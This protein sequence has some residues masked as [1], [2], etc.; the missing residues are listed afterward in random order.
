[1]RIELIN[2][3]DEL[4]TDFELETNPFKVGETINVVITNHKTTFWNVK[5]L[6][7]DYVVDSISHYLRKTYGDQSYS[8]VF[9]VSV[10]VSEISLLEEDCPST[11]SSLP[12]CFEGLPRTFFIDLVMWENSFYCNECG[13]EEKIDFIFTRKV[14]N[15][16]VWYCKHCKTETVVG[17]KPN[18]DNY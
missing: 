13:C 18:E 17:N 2:A 1:M 7:G 9:T 4:I 14:V 5:D 16:E 6:H 12:D 15:G 3:Q 10:K 8:M 11:M